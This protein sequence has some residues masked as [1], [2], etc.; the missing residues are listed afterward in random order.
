M[1]RDFSTR[2]RNELLELVR[3]V[4]NEKWCDFTDWFGDR[5]YDFES[6]INQ[7]NIKNYLNNVN[8]YHKKVIDK[9]NATCDTINSI[10]DKVQLVD[11]TY[12]TTFHA[13]DVQLMLVKQYIDQM[14]D[15][16][17]PAKGMFDGTYISSTLG[18]LLEKYNNYLSE[19]SKL[20]IGSFQNSENAEIIGSFDVTSFFMDNRN[21]TIDNIALFWTSDW[22]SNALSYFYIPAGITPQEFLAIASKAFLENINDPTGWNI[23]NSIYKE[24]SERPES[25]QLGENVNEKLTRES[26]ESLIKSTLVNKHEVTDT[27]DDIISSLTP[28]EAELGKKIINYFMKAGKAVTQE[29]LAEILDIDIKKLTESD[30]L[31][32]L[33]QTDNME[34]LSSLSSVFDKVDTVSDGVDYLEIGA[35]VIA[36]IFND[37]TEDAE[38]LEAI[39]KA[40][41]ESGCDNKTVEKVVNEMLW[42]YKNQYVSALQTGV[43]Q[44]AQKAVEDGSKELVKLASADVATLVTLFLSGK[45]ITNSVIGLNDKTDSMST[46]YATAQYSYMLVNKY[47]YYRDRVNSGNYTADDIKQRDT[48]FQLAKE[49]KLQEYRAIKEVTEDALNS[50]SAFFKSDE[51]KAY[52]RSI[53]AQIDAEIQRLESM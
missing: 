13:L 39:K 50:T 12:R 37:Y 10:F 36:K 19:I 11:Y 7:L 20:G 9:N 4:E 25:I 33:S 31:N 49:A 21:S 1:Y 24:L 40:L 14:G 29:E 32:W 26:I 35:D 47:K 22:L 3:Q 45:D 30:Y 53:L 15:I 23:M 6:W 41:Q 2:S 18:K 8:A 17:N 42:E 34:F 51:D 43:E 16:V 38:Y 44:L 5:W 28:D 48:Y 27:A 46:V 52:T